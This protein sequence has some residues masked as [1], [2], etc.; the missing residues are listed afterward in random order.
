MCFATETSLKSLKQLERVKGIVISLEGCCS[1]DGLVMNRTPGLFLR[2][3]LHSLP[4]N[5]ARLPAAAAGHLLLT[6]GMGG[7]GDDSRGFAALV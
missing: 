5:S 1:I 2:L 3:G 4:P 6:W 7:A